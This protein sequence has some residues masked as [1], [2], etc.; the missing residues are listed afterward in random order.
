MRCASRG[1]LLRG[2]GY[3]QQRQGVGV[4]VRAEA[5]FVL[6]VQSPDPARSPSNLWGVDGGGSHTTAVV[7]CPGADVSC[8]RFASISIGTVG[9]D[10]AVAG[11]TKVFKFVRSELPAD[12]LAFGCVG[13]SSVPVAMESP[14]PDAFVRA[15][16]SYAPAGSVLL[17]NDMVPLLYAPPLGGMGVAISSGTGSC[18]LG[19]SGPGRMAKIGGHEYV[20]S[21]EGSAY[22]LGRAALCAAASAIDGTGPATILSELATKHF[23]MTIPALGRWLAE[24]RSVRATVAGFAPVVLDASADSVAMEII[25]SNAA[26]LAAAVIVALDRLDLGAEPTLGFSG[27]VVRGSESYRALIERFVRARGFRPRTHVLD[28][29]SAVLS[30]AVQLADENCGRAVTSPRPGRDE[31]LHLAVAAAAHPS[32]GLS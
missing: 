18:V 24:I 1:D 26:S 21:D 11:L 15:I 6:R 23:G 13:A 16:E 17:V 2:A 5:S 30:M 9:H 20:L 3:E 14:Y 31:G 25:E 29:E 19:R 4:D 22:S 28:G 27:G 8:Q 12:Q 7:A 10:A 32:R